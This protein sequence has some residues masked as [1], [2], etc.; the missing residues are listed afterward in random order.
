MNTAIT[1][2]TA[3]MSSPGAILVKA[4]R[5]GLR[6]DKAGRLGYNREPI[7]AAQALCFGSIRR[8]QIDPNC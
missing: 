5:L 1:N 6:E 8:W 4:G 2:L 3:R 7:G